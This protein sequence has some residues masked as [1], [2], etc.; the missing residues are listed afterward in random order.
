MSAS[1]AGECTYSENIFGD[2]FTAVL[3]LPVPR[4]SR[5][6]PLGQDCG[7]TMAGL[8]Q[9]RGRTGVL[10]M[11]PDPILASVP[12]PTS[13]LRFRESLLLLVYYHAY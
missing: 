3:V 11:L 10:E 1:A 8:G 12:L 13:F 2:Q 7:R 6:G 5:A 4:A 9:D